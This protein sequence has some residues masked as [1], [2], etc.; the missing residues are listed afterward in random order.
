MNCIKPCITTSI[1]AAKVLVCF[2][3][4]IPKSTFWKK[5]M[6]KARLAETKMQLFGKSCVLGLWRESA[7]WERSSELHFGKSSCAFIYISWTHK[8][9]TKLP[10]DKSNDKLH[11]VPH[12]SNLSALASALSI[13]NFQIQTQKNLYQIHKLAKGRKKKINPLQ[14]RIP[15]NEKQ[16]NFRI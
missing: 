3:F 1:H 5:S 12:S 4:F 10:F 8:K 13:T 9:I 7:R 15:Q 2:H 14:I 6:S 11:T 16:K